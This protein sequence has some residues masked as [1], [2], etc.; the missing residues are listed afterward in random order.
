MTR[1][2]SPPPNWRGCSNAAGQPI[3]VLDEE[4]TIVFCNRGVPAIGWAGGR[5]AAR[6]AV[7]LSFA[8][9]TLTGPDAVAAGLC[10]PPAV[11]A[12]AN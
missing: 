3:Y 7:R 5:R 10:P 2:A 12:R 11:L 4:L 1:H 9:R 8:A 6:P